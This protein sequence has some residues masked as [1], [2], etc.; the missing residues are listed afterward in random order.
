[1]VYDVWQSPQA[2]QAFGP[3]LMP[4]LAEVG[5]DPASPAS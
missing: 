4:L 1:M 5:V 2:F 3:V